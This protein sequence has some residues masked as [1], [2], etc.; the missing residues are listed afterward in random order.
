MKPSMAIHHCVPSSGNASFHAFHWHPPYHASHGHAFFVFII[1]IFN[2]EHY[3][4][5]YVIAYGCSDMKS[6][7][8]QFIAVCLLWHFITLSLLWQ[9]IILSLP[10]QCISFFA[11]NG[12]SWYQPMHFLYDNSPYF[13]RFK[14]AEPQQFQQ[15]NISH[16]NVDF[17]VKLK[18]L[19]LTAKIQQLSSNIWT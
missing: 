16:N 19:N 1:Y 9:F 10:W 3:M 13:F 8:W 5:V 2:V 18:Y 6:H 11:Y 15:S 4:V 14:S 7:A 17:P 12:H